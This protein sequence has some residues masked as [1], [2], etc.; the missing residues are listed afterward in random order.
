MAML[1]RAGTE[2]ECEV[3]HYASEGR[4]KARKLTAELSGHSLDPW[5]LHSAGE[6]IG[7]SR[8][9]DAIAL[10]RRFR[11]AERRAPSAER[12]NDNHSGSGCADRA[13]TPLFRPPLARAKMRKSFLSPNSTKTRSTP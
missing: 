13:A 11:H 8:R 10:E 5:Q 12:T 2:T 9:I 7:K 4:R 1:G 3:R 6:L